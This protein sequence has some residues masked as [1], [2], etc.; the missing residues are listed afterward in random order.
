MGLPLGSACC[1]WGRPPEAAASRPPPQAA[2]EPPRPS[3]C[4]VG[5]AHRP[6]CPLAEGR[7]NGQCNSMCEWWKKSKRYNKSITKSIIL[8]H[9][10]HLSNQTRASSDNHLWCSPYDFLEV[11]AWAYLFQETK[12]E[13][14][15]SG[16]GGVEARDGFVEDVGIEASAGGG[17]SAQRSQHETRLLPRHSLLNLF[18][19]FLDVW[20][21]D[22]QGIHWSPLI[23]MEAY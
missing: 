13:V 12:Q 23:Q 8:H 1:W 2:E 4:E 5:T 19:M 20:W 3:P 6:L 21:R 17:Q 10:L 7:E 9:S 16:V 22:K 14:L 11:L 15:A 18:H